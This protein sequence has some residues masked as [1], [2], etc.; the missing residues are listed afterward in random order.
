MSVPFPYKIIGDVFDSDILVKQIYNHIFPMFRNRFNFLDV[1]EN[2]IEVLQNNHKNHSIIILFYDT[3][4]KTY[5]E[6]I[7]ISLG[8]RL[9]ALF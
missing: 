3:A 4:L 7:S 2:F 6:S 1:P 5:L 9:K 8:C